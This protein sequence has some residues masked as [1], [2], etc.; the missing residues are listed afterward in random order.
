VSEQEQVPHSDERNAL[1]AY[2][3]PQPLADAICDRLLKIYP[4][5]DFII[6]PSAGM[7]AFVRSCTSRWPG[8]MI[9]AVDIDPRYNEAC[10][11]AGAQAFYPEDWVQFI[12]RVDFTQNK[13]LMLGNPPF[14]HAQAHVEAG[15]ARLG[16][17][18]S[19]ALLLKD[20][21]FGGKD[22]AHNLFPKGQM[23]YF[24]PI[25]SRPSFKTT[26]KAVNDTNEYGVF[27]W[28]VGYTGRPEILFP[29]I[30]W[31][32]PRV[33]KA[34]TSRV[35]KVIQRVLGLPQD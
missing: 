24:I 17:G 28:E 14:K 31:R 11:S 15:L 32:K 9:L 25:L 5:P 30:E 27:I 12:H 18:S 26:S 16:V 22:R 19:I 13:V 6:E 10:L 21:F 29:H 4:S 34:K 7:G 8:K 20:N 1:D 2:F 33:K 23:R 35:K 3:T